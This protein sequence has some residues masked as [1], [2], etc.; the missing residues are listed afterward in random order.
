MNKKKA[1]IREKF[2]WEKSLQE[3]EAQMVKILR[4]S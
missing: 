4:K 2:L 3:N 1:F